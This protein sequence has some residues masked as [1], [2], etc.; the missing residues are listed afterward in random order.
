MDNVPDTIYFQIDE[1]WTPESGHHPFQNATWSVDPV[2]ESDVLYI[3]AL[4]P[5]ELR[6][7]LPPD[8]N[9][10][11]YQPRDTERRIRRILRNT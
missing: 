9:E 11:G 1:D 10:S 2:N 4:D 5:A 7:T 6:A 3:R 8:D